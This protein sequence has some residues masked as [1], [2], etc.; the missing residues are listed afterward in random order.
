MTVDF[1]DDED[2]E[3]LVDVI[4]ARE[5]R[6]TVVQ[7]QKYRP[8]LASINFPTFDGVDEDIYV[9]AGFVKPGRQVLIIYDPYDREFYQRDIVVE[10]RRSEIILQ[11]ADSK[12]QKDPAE[13]D[14][15]FEQDDFIF[16]DWRRD[17]MENIHHNCQTDL[18]SE[19]FSSSWM[20]IPKALYFKILDYISNNY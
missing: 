10:V 13:D 19:I 11:K 4:A 18:D 2:G 12:N 20:G 17:T 3:D 14:C 8:D 5:W 9:F 7:C 6:E 1:S 15:L 16:K